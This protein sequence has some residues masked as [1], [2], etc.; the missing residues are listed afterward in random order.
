MKFK[1]LSLAI[2]AC[3]ML[4]SCSDDFLQDKKNYDSV[5]EDAYNHYLSLIHI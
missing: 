1:Y 5:N 4:S 3:G 2:L